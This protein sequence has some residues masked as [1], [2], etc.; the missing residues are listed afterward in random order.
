MTSLALL[1]LP[2]AVYAAL[3][4]TGAVLGAD[5]SCPCAWGCR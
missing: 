1:L 4:I 2:G 3:L 5:D